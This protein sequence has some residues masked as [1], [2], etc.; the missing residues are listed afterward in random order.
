MKKLF[1]LGLLMVSLFIA[2]KSLPVLAQADPE[3]PGGNSAEK[4]TVA[5]SCLTSTTPIDELRQASRGEGKQRINLVGNC[6]SDLGFCYISTCITTADD[7]R[8]TTGNNTYDEVIGYGKNNY[9]S[10]QAKIPYFFFEVIPYAK[11]QSTGNVNVDAKIL[12]EPSLQ[13]SFFAIGQRTTKVSNPGDSNALEYGTF[14]FEGEEQCM[15][16]RAD[17]Y[18]VVFDSQSLEPLPDVTVTLLG[19]SKN[20]YKLEG[21][22][23]PV[24]TE[25]DGLF[26]FV[27]PAGMYYLTPQTIKKYGFEMQPYI[28]PNYVRAY[29]NI[30]KPDE[31]IN[32]NPD[33]PEHRDIAL[34][35]GVNQPYRGTPVNMKYG[36]YQHGDVFKISGKQSHPLTVITFKQGDKEIKST[37]ADRFGFYEVLIPNVDL[38]P[39]SKID[40]YLT[41]VDLTQETQTAQPKKSISINPYPPYIEGKAINPKT[42]GVVPN[43]KVV[44]KIKGSDKVESQ[45]DA[46]QNGIFKFNPDEVPII[47]YFLE[48]TAPNSLASVKQ[49]PVEF[50]SLNKEYLAANNINLMTATKNGVPPMEKRKEDLPSETTQM[51]EENTGSQGNLNQLPTTQP[52]QSNSSLVLALSM[53]LILIVAVGV[54]VYFKLKK[55][56]GL[57]EEPQAPPTMV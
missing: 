50:A 39:D 54:L 32:E 57:D 15:T 13:W 31:V 4:M 10:L 26:N 12:A 25:V 33:M 20:V 44:I 2:S 8:C 34:N 43:A 45:T 27:V 37:S 18:G 21:V 7:T 46:D 16:Y 14:E 38:L 30:Y 11:Y 41:K 24:Q 56:G 52:E 40:V 19:D 47:P 28:H 1:F 22:P 42:G 17:P 53:L 5:R 35:P 36:T 29:S 6:E 55:K 49:T 3:L 23:N 9:T 48:I 51:P